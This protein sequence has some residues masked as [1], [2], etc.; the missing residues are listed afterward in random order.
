MKRGVALSLVGSVVLVGLAGCGRGWIEERAPWRHDAEVACL[1]SG[2]VKEGPAITA[3]RP[4]DGPG[5]CGADFPL[6]VAALGSSQALGFAD[7]PRPPGAIPQYRAGTGTSYNPIPAYPV[8]PPYPASQTPYPA[9]QAPYPASQ[10]PS[11]GSQIP[12]ASPLS[13]SPP[14]PEPSRGDVVEPASDPPMYGAPRPIEPARHPPGQVP[15]GPAPTPAM[16]G[17]AGVAPAATLACPVVSALDSWVMHGVQPA[18]LRWFGEP[19]VEIKQI[20]AYSCRPM[21]GQR[22][23]PISEHAFGTALDIAAF[24]LADGRRITVRDGWHGATAERAFL[25][26]VQGAACELFTTVLAPGSNAFHYDHIHVDLARHRSGRSICKPAPISGEL[27]A[28]G[29]GGITGSLG[30]SRGPGT[31]TRSGRSS[32][33][34]DRYDEGED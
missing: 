9:S 29:E 23:N 31:W 25:H 30:R 3:L 19:V 2:A 15:L 8:Q 34:D 7:D 13:I 6:K 14:E 32:D 4:I 27:I 26:D 21:N 17:P 20:S 11:P 16:A 22:G 24:T 10:A 18:A 12:A 1:K 5:I 33:E 28:R